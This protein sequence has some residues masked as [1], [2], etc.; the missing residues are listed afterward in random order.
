MEKLKHLL[1][2][3]RL[4]GDNTKFNGLIKCGVINA[5]RSVIVLANDGL[6]P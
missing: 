5:K 1:L 3:Q 2:W 6:V 4:G